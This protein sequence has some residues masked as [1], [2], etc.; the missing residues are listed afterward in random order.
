MNSVTVSDRD[1]KIIIVILWRSFGNTIRTLDKINLTQ[2]SDLWNSITLVF[3]Q[4]LTKTGV[5]GLTDKIVA[6]KLKVCEKETGNF[7]IQDDRNNNKRI[8]RMSEI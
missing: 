3:S 4:Y 1:K 8:N 6:D 5:K 2:N 7:I